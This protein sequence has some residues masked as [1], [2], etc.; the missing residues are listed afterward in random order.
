MPLRLLCYSTRQA[1]V[2]R[3]SSVA[4]AALVSS[5]KLMSTSP[6]IVR[7][8]VNE[9]NEAV[10]SD[11]VMVQYHALGTCQSLSF[12][13]CRIYVWC[14]LWD[15]CLHDAGSVSFDLPIGFVYD[16]AFTKFHALPLFSG[17]LYSIRKNDRQGV[18]KLVSRFTKSSLRSPFA[19]CL[20][21]RIA[22]KL[23]EGDP[24]GKASQVIWICPSIYQ[25][26]KPW[27]SD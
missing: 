18:S 5:L 12:V 8:W 1:I 9:A 16:H 10:N 19:V 22:C 2:D 15:W 14:S 26:I 21:I 24:D 17:L 23:I 6:D 27:M 25:S 13:E 3:V 7:R 4:S 11:N 20:L